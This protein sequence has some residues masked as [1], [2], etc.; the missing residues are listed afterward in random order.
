VY[1]PVYSPEEGLKV[2]L[3]DKST[4]QEIVLPLDSAIGTILIK[5]FD[6]YHKYSEDKLI[7]AYKLV[8]SCFL[9][10]VEPNHDIDYLVLSII[11]AKNRN[12]E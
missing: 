5:V 3:E 8:K 1:K 4:G 6:Q 2:G 9:C 7:Q 11:N 12:T 10:Y